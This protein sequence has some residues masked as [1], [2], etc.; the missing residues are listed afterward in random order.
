MQYLAL[1]QTCPKSGLQI[2][3]DF[4]DL[5]F[6]FIDP[7]ETI[8]TLHVLHVFTILVFIVLI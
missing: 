6:S 8:M 2:I 7:I 5:R 4:E 3:T 1:D